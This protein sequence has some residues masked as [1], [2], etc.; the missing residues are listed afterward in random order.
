MSNPYASSVNLKLLGLPN[1][2]LASPIGSATT[3]PLPQSDIFVPAVGSL[4][5][6][7]VPRTPRLP[8]SPALRRPQGWATPDYVLFGQQSD[9]VVSGN[10]IYFAGQ[11]GAPS[12][13]LGMSAFSGEVVYFAFQYNPN[14]ATCGLAGGPASSGFNAVFAVGAPT[15]PLQPWHV[16]LSV[17][18]SSLTLGFGEQ[19][20]LG[21]ALGTCDSK[22]N[23]AWVVLPASVSNVIGLTEGLS[24]DYTNVL[25]DTGTL[26][27]ETS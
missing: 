16:T 25:G 24:S 7:R 9:K 15:S 5:G 23:C 12:S 18:A 6:H 10:L 21:S 20:V 14:G 3:S 8:C 26:W 17:G 27:V 2:V 1:G 22:R 19:D 13:G 11:N 4:S